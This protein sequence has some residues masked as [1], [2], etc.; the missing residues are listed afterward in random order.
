MGVTPSVPLRVGLDTTTHT[1]TVYY[2]DEKSVVT[3]RE[4]MALASTPRDVAMHTRQRCGELR[5]RLK[6]ATPKKRIEFEGP[7]TRLRRELEDARKQGP[8][9]EHSTADLLRTLEVEF[10]LPRGSLYRS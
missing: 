7:L 10:D 1:W 8:M 6:K 2:E 3:V 5:L 4:A 9:S